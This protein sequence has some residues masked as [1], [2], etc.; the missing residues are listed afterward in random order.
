[1]R[2]SERITLAVL[3]VAL[4]TPGLTCAGAVPSEPYGWKN[5]KI[6]GGGFIPGIVFNTKQP[7]LAF[8]RTD[9]GSSYK[10]DAKAGQWIPLTDWCGVSNLFGSESIATDP[11]DPNR[12]YI[13]Q[14]MYSNDVSAIMRSMDQGKTFQVIDVPF[15]MGGNEMGRSVGERLALDPGENNILYFGSRRDGLWISKD[16]ALTWG[17]V[18]SFPATGSARGRGVG[19]SFVVFDAAGATPGKATN[20]IYVGSTDPCDTHLFR[21]TDAGHTWA[22]VPGQPKEFVPIHGAFDTQGMLYLVYDNGPGPYGVT[23]GAVWK[24]NT[25]DGMWT[26]ITPDKDPS[27]P[28][29]GYG[30]IAVDLHRPGAVVVA[31]LNRKI[32]GG[33]DEYRIYR[34]VDG[35]KTW[36]DLSDKTHRDASATPYVTWIGKPV[37]DLDKDPAPSL[38]WWIATLAIDPFDSNHVCYATGTTIWNCAD[39]GNADL[40]KDTHWSVWTEGIE[41]TAILDLASPTEGAHLISAFGDIGGYTH[42]DLDASPKVEEMHLHPLFTN[43]NTVDYAEKN[44]KIV[45]RTGTPA[46]HI[47]DRDTMAYS[48]DGGRTWKP[49]ALGQAA[50]AGGRGGF[51]GRGGGVIL[52]ADGSTFMSLGATPQIS[53]DRG[54]TWTSCQGLFRGA[55]PVADRVDPAKFYAVS[56]GAGKIYRSTDGGATFAAADTSGLPAQASGGLPLKATPGKEGDLWLVGR[57]GLYHSFDGGAAFTQVGNTLSVIVLGFGKA[58]PGRDYPALYVAGTYSNQPGIFRSDD[59]GTTWVR[60]NDNQHQYGNRFRCITGDPR[61]YG[62]VYVGTDGRGILYGDR[63]P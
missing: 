54:K 27:R 49:F 10:W 63:A 37:G 16:A 23:N 21:S 53:K 3:S 51:G 59:A 34:T 45:I 30:G 12:L 11:V 46:L 48:E 31:T 1:M 18:T 7:G 15:R 58:G 39:F 36:K 22:A 33:D 4:A 5:V 52:N 38:G 56:I 40:D 32:P 20:T 50:S 13:A 2:M 28:P 9:I 55:R 6:G 60:I 41:E 57:S 24:L 62:R 43:T 17:K 19:L 61:I 35:G 44:P 25:K 29:G 14:G 26:D 42:G 8:C 47:P